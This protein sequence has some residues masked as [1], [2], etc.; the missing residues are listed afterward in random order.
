MFLFPTR[1]LPDATSIHREV[2]IKNL[3][4]N[5][6]ETFFLTG[7]NE[8]TNV[9]VCFSFANRAIIREC[10]R[11]ANSDMGVNIVEERLTERAAKVAELEAAAAG[12][13]VTNAMCAA[14]FC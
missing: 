5:H 10:R 3:N 11:P 14:S 13:V 7:Q 1:D 2:I 8:F 6:E 4:L 9:T 12:I